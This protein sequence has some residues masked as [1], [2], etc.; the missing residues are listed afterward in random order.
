M[1][2]NVK[3]SLKS[4]VATIRP[5]PRHDGAAL[6]EGGPSE[7]EPLTPAQTARALFDGPLL[8][9][10]EAARLLNVSPRTLEA[11][12]WNGQGPEFVKL[13]AKAIRYRS[14][15]LHAWVSAQRFASTAAVTVAGAR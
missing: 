5:T 9:Q 2:L 12:R 10:P 1:S 3:T 11:W 6:V 7:A 15:D 4:S 13:G 14:C 8:T